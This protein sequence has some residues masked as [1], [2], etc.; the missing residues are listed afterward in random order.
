MRL[1]VLR[2]IDTG[3]KRTWLVEELE[4]AFG[5]RIESYLKRRYYG[6][7]WSYGAI[8]D[9]LA[10]AE[11]TVGRWMTQLGYTLRQV[12]Y[13]ATASDSALRVH[14]PD[15]PMKRPKRGKRSAA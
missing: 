8:A 13:E 14:L 6:N 3:F 15:K 7:R 10:I 1:R 4:A 9:E 11:G 12:A 2:G 5:F